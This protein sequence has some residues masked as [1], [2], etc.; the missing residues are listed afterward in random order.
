MHSNFSEKYLSIFELGTVNSNPAVK[1]LKECEMCPITLAAMVTAL[2]ETV[3]R[4]VDESNQNAYEKA[5][6]KALKKIMKD[7]HNYDITYRQIN[8]NEDLY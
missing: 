5:F 6:N 2:F 4:T 3:M 1:V 7:R 8:I